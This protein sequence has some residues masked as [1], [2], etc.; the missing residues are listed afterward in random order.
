MRGMIL[1]AGKGERMR[2]AFGGMHKAL[3]PVGGVPLIVRLARSLAGA[4]IAPLVVNVCHQA[5]RIAAALGD[6]DAVGCPIAYSRERVALETAGGIANALPLLGDATFL[7]ANADVWV[8][9]DFA[10]FA[11][12]GLAAMR[13]AGSRAHLLLA[14]NPEHNPGGDFDLDGGRALRPPGSRG[15]TFTGIGLYDP[16]AFAGVAP[17]E[18]APLIGILEPLAA[19]GLVSG[20]QT[21]A[22][23]RDVGTPERYLEVSG[24]EGAGAP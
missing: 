14:P 17:G 9:I 16:A 8:E 21:A 12:D 3:L 11:R 15:L 4:G 2:G 5:D 7:A 10:A 6:G 19:R 20:E 13:A 22:P 18:K 1:A 24:A 23:W